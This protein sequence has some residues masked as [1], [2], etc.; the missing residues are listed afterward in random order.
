MSEGSVVILIVNIEGYYY[1][2]MDELFF[3]YDFFWICYCRFEI[4][5][6]IWINIVFGIDC[7]ILIGRVMI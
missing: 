1:D 2:V 6:I 4:D 5:Y 7:F 3:F